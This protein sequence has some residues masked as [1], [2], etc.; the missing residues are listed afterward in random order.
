MRNVLLGVPR[1]TNDEPASSASS[2][3]ILSAIRAALSSQNDSRESNAKPC[4]AASATTAF[5]IRRP[6]APRFFGARWLVISDRFSAYDSHRFSDF[7]GRRPLFRAGT[8]PSQP[9]VCYG[10]SLRASTLGVT[11]YPSGLDGALP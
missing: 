5:Q 1:T 2:S 10:F 3:A 4:S 7:R 9:R 6:S 11:H 8:D